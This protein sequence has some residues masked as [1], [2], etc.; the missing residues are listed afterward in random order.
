MA[1]VAEAEPAVNSLDDFRQQVRDW[2][3]ANFPAS[4][5]GHDHSL[6]ALEGPSARTWARKASISAREDAAGVLPPS[7]G[8]GVRSLVI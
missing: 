5:K 8:A 6:S 3:A 4:L 1:S 2:L 7:V